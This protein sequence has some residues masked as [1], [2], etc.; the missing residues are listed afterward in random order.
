MTDFDEVIQEIST[1]D[2][3]KD[4]AN[5]INNGKEQIQNVFDIYSRVTKSIVDWCGSIRPLLQEFINGDDNLK[6]Q[7]QKVLSETALNGSIHK[8]QALQQEVHNGITNL[9]NVIKDIVSVLSRISTDFDSKTNEFKEANREIYKN[10]EIK[11]QNLEL[12][13]KDLRTKLEFEIQDIYDLQIHT[14]G[15]KDVLASEVYPEFHDDIVESLKGDCRK[16][17]TKHSMIDYVVLN[18]S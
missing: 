14:E 4:L 5:R 3:L 11:F 12:N 16:Y 1:Q 10:L 6:S 13:I 2:F 17:Y 9:D 8:I 18:G 7:A 15:T